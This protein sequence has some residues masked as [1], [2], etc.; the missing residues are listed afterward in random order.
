M[1]VSF[2]GVKSVNVPLFCNDRHLCEDCA[3][4]KTMNSMAHG[5]EALD[6]RQHHSST[7][8]ATVGAL[9]SSV[10][11]SIS[12][13]GAGAGRIRQITSPYGRPSPAGQ[14]TSALNYPHSARK[15]AKES[16]KMKGFNLNTQTLLTIA[17]TDTIMN[18]LQSLDSCNFSLVANLSETSLN[19]FGSGGGGGG[20]GDSSSS[21]DLQGLKHLQQQRI[22][23]RL[24]AILEAADPT[25]S[26]LD[27]SLALD[28]P[29]EEVRAC[30]SM[31]FL[32][33]QS[34]IIEVIHFSSINYFIFMHFICSS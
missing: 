21:G 19:A 27:L 23:T 1:N 14:L 3:H 32:H 24:V 16:A 13:A 9:S 5:V 29:V 6:N 30:M 12:G 34:K 18:I 31:D 20:D 11:I 15:S 7:T 10:T 8:G 28:E 22:S 2:N 26:F 25:Q 17:D 4:L 33:N